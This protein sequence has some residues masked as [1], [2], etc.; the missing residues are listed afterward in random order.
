MANWQDAVLQAV[1]QNLAG[2]AMGSKPPAEAVESGS[3]LVEKLSNL[4]EDDVFTWDDGR[5][6]MFTD[7]GRDVPGG[8]TPISRD[9]FLSLIVGMGE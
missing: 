7:S 6:Y 4:P 9:D 8:V 3:S 2:G 1:M 5:R